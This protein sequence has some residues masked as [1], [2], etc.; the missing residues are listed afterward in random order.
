MPSCF[1]NSGVHFSS[2]SSKSGVP[3]INSSR[4]VPGSALNCF[5]PIFK[6]ATFCAIPPSNDDSKAFAIY[7]FSPSVIFTQKPRV[8]AGSSSLFARKTER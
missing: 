6:S 3:L 7:T 2:G 5:G 8:V 1:I 4:I